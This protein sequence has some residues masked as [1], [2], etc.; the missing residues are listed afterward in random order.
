MYVRTKCGHLHIFIALCHFHRTLPLFILLSRLVAPS[1]LSLL[2]TCV[3]SSMSC[4]SSLSL[5]YAC[6][7]AINHVLLCSLSS[8]SLLLLHV[9]IYARLAMS[10]LLSCATV[11]CLLMFSLSSSPPLLPCTFIHALSSLLRSHDPSSEG[12]AGQAARSGAGEVGSSR[13]V[14]SR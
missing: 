5:S 4:P 2:C 13:Q 12:P 9:Y 6:V 14:S 7:Y 10:C 11:S 8:L 1:A 3:Y